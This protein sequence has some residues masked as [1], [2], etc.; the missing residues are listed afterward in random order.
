MLPFNPFSLDQLVIDEAA[1]Q[2]IQGSSANISQ[3]ITR[4]Q[5]YYFMPVRPAV[6]VDSSQYTDC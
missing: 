3:A 6:E 2:W 5:S 1:K 4:Q